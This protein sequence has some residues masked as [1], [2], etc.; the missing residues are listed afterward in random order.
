VGKTP[1]VQNDRGGVFLSGR[2]GRGSAKVVRLTLKR[3]RKKARL[4]L[5][6]QDTSF[7]RGHRKGK[8][9]DGGRGFFTTF[10]W[11]LSSLVLTEDVVL[12]KE[13]KW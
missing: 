2:T 10:H 9:F 3:G 5:V 13:L 1:G 11:E 12:L 7:Y 8:G 4:W 6:L